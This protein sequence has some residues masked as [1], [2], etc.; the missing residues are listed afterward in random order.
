MALADILSAMVAVVKSADIANVYPYQPLVVN[1]SQIPAALIDQNQVHFWSVTREATAEVR[2]N[3]VE[4]QRNHTLVIR[5]YY[6]VREASVSEPRFQHL[7][8]AVMAA[9][10][11]LYSLD[12]PASVEWLLPAQA[13]EIGPRMLSDTFLVHYVELRL[14]AQ[15]RVRP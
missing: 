8:E 12:T 3:N 13:S 11:A 10:R 2:L 15:E 14:D 5:G 9:C 1:G 4:T 7:I 6:E